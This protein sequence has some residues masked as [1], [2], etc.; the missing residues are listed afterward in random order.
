MQRRLGLFGIRTL[1]ELASLAPGAVQSQFGREGLKAWRLARGED[2]EPVRG[3]Q[4]EA[5]I[6]RRLTFPSPTASIDS[7]LIALRQLITKA[8]AAPA[9]HNRGVRRIHLQTRLSGSRSW[10][11]TLT[12]REPSGDS[13]QVFFALKSLIGNL[14]L[15]GPVE[16]VMVQ[17]SGLCGETGKQ[18]GM[19]TGNSGRDRQLEESIRQLKARFGRTPIYRM[20]EVEPWSRIPERRRALIDFDP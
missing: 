5:A 19:F 14:V 6:V 13:G 9:L 4:R 1:G 20:V 17:I 18:Q 8:F 11:R 10:E 2:N 16:E 15:P 7:L 3:R 12:L